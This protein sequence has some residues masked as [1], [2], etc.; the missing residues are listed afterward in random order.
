M[1][2]FGEARLCCASARYPRPLLE[3][4]RI[5]ASTACISD[6]PENNAFVAERRQVLG[7][8]D[9]ILMATHKDNQ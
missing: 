9:D 7:P 1:R 3:Q 5:C 4:W 6:Q 8:E 2:Y